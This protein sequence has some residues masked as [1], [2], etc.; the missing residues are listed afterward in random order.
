MTMPYAGDGAMANPSQYPPL[1]GLDTSA[2]DFQPVGVAAAGTAGKA[3]DAGHVHPTGYREQDFG[4]IDLGYLA[5]SYD[6]I[7][8]SA[9]SAPTLTVVTLI[10]I[11]VRQALSVTNVIV[12]LNGTGSGLTSGQNF[13]GL[14]AGQT[15]GA[16][17]AGQLIGTSADQTSAWG[18]AG[19]KIAALASGPFPLPA[20]TFVWAALLV[21]ASSS[22]PTFTR[23]SSPATAAMSNA[24]LAAAAARYATATGGTSLPGSITPGSNTL[25]GQTYWAALS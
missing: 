14:Y 11:N 24:G 6:P 20:N 16:Y 23:C 25:I 1:G 13:A 3:A 17:T 4:P 7:L 10:R 21:N 5:W 19:I 9:A 15:A 22:A 2:A 18:T 8:I 12:A